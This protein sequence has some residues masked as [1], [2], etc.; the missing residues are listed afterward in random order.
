MLGANSYT[1]LIIPG[2]YVNWCRVMQRRTFAYQDLYLP[3]K[4]TSLIEAFRKIIMKSLF[5]L[6]GRI[7]SFLLKNLLPDIKN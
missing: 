6:Y 1:A 5:S 7:L 4:S 3:I 2:K